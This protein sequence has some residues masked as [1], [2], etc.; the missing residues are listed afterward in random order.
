MKVVVDGNIGSGKTTQLGLLEK[1]GFIVFREPID[2]W[3]LQE[4]Y[5]DPK[6]GIFPL[7]MTILRTLRPRGPGVYERS[8]LSSR[9]VF[10]EWAKAKGA[11]PHDATYDYFYERHKWQPDL[12]I[13][14]SKSPEKCFEAIQK[15]GQTGDGFVTLEYLQELDTLY[16]KLVMKVPCKVHILNADSPPEEIH[17]KILNILSHNEYTV[18][19]GDGERRQVQK[20]GGL[21]GSVLCTPFKD[22][23]RLS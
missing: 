6:N 7:H 2:E 16:Q 14:L 13:F 20:S 15:R 23:C 21:G 4:F 19:V 3:P 18:L 17:E 1:K 8:L 22:L 9:W 10:W 11:S 5:E 12:Y